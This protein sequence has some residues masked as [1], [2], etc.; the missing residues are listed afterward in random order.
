MYSRKISEVPESIISDGEAAFGTYMSVPK[1]LDI[2]GMKNPFVTVPL[3]SFFTNF[4]IKSRLAYMFRLGDY[5]GI[6]E[7]FDDK[8]FGFAELIF[9]NTK[10]GKRF[11]YPTLMFFRRRFVPTKTDSAVCT[12]HQKAHQIRI[13]WS[14]KYKRATVSFDIKKRSGKPRVFGNFVSSFGDNNHSE[15]LAVMPHPNARRCSASGVSILKIK[16]SISLVQDKKNETEQM[17]TTDGLAVMVLNRTYHRYHS[18]SEMMCAIGE[19]E[20][21]TIQFRFTSTSSEANDTDEYNENVFSVNGIITPMP[22][23]C[24]THPF[25]I[26]KEWII[27]DTESMIDLTFTPVSVARRILNIF[28]MRSHYNTIYGTFDGVLVDG[29]GNKYSLKKFPGIVKKHTLR[30]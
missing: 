20:G 21:K 10:T 12:T 25:G 9:W 29:S 1:K 14:R 24:I 30:V 19:H 28:I 15:M 5:I 2:R 17:Q 3:P 8:V 7:F 6:I 18:K 27:Q 23:V 22:A 11:S 13:W 26:R 4:R 16:G